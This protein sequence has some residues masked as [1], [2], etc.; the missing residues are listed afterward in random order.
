VC[1]VDQSQN[2]SRCQRAVP[3]ALSSRDNLDTSRHLSHSLLSLRLSSL[4]LRLSPGCTRPLVLM[5]RLLAIQRVLLRVIKCFFAAVSGVR[6]ARVSTA[7]N[8]VSTRFPSLVLPQGIS[9]QAYYNRHALFGRTGT[10]SNDRGWTELAAFF[11]RS[12]IIGGRRR[13]VVVTS[14][15][16][17]RSKV[18]SDKVLS[19][20]S[21]ASLIMCCSCSFRG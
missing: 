3:Q 12:T 4:S 21:K 16:V 2:S 19:V 8:S 15:G 1:A 20:C 9:E 13:G 17:L 11:R 10:A 7:A 14:V 5:L 6:C 18:S